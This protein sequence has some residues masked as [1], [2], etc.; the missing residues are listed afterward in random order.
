MTDGASFEVAHEVT[1]RKSPNNTAASPN[2]IMVTSKFHG[3]CEGMECNK[4]R[5]KVD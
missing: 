4:S 2:L 3:Y 5:Q 1:K